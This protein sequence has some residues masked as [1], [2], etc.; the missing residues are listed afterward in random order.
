MIIGSMCYARMESLLQLNFSMGLTALFDI[1]YTI[2][3]LTDDG[4]L[5]DANPTLQP[6]YL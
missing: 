6:E 2:C 4:V 1:Y 5:I 3:S